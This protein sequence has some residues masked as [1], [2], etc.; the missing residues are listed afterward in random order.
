MPIKKLTNHWNSVL[1]LPTSFQKSARRMC[2]ILSRSTTC[3]RSS[4]FNWFKKLAR[5][6]ARV[7]ESMYLFNQRIL[8]KGILKP[9]MFIHFMKFKICQR[10]LSKQLK[11]QTAKWLWQSKLVFQSRTTCSQRHLKC[12]SLMNHLLTSQRRFKG[13]CGSSKTRTSSNHSQW[14]SWSFKPMITLLL[15]SARIR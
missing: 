4:T 5:C 3:E 14:F 10:I 13:M 8:I 12:S 11:N 6:S 9:L 1:N 2:R 7:E 15:T